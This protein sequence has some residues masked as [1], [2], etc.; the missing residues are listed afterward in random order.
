M[1]SYMVRT[2][3]NLV[4]ETG[5]LSS[6]NRKPGKP[7]CA[8]TVKED[9]ELYFSDEVSHVMPGKKRFFFQFM[10]MELKLMHKSILY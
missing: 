1:V 10:L 2:A 6:P 8:K 4:K 5:M 9:H 3:K 7:L